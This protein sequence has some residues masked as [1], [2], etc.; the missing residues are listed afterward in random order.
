M[1]IKKEVQDLVEQA[2]KQGWKVVR[3]NSGHRKWMSPTG[4]IVFTSCTPSDN[5]ALFRIKRD[6]R[7]NGFIEVKT[8]KRRK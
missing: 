5:R 2:E 6:L 8:G 3:V 4:S 1:S 7:N